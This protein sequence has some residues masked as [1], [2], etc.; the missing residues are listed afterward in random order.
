[1]TG[2]TTAGE[3][4]S[5]A[6][7]SLQELT[8]EIGTGPVVDPRGL[9]AAWPAFQR[10]GE[11]LLVVITA[12]P[13]EAFDVLSP[14]RSTGVLDVA[15]SE[16][17][18][19]RLV[20]AAD[21]LHAAADLLAGRDRSALTSAVRLNDAAL[22]SEP[23]LTGAYLVAHA[24]LRDPA[25]FDV[26][27][28]AVQ[29]VAR[30]SATAGS[31][32]GQRSELGGT[33]ED[34]TTLPTGVRHSF[35][36]G[37]LPSAESALDV[38]QL[39][40]VAIH[41]WEK[42]AVAAGQLAAPS[43]LDLRGSAR[44]AGSLLALT[45][46]LLRSYPT[47]TGPDKEPL[48]AAASRIQAAGISW[49]AA[50]DWGVVT[51]ATPADPT[52][53]TAT[54]ALDQAISLVAR[55]GGH[56]ASPDEVARRLDA[57]HAFTVA[58]SALAALQIVAEQHAPVITRL[59]DT[60]TLYA[61]AVK[62]T[63]TMERV[64]DRIARRWVPVT[65]AEARE[66]LEAYRQL[67]DRTA[68]ARLAFTAVTSPES[69]RTSETVRFTMS[70]RAAASHAAVVARPSR[71]DAV[72]APDET[73]A[74]QRWQRT[75]EALDPRLLADPHW[76]TLA[77]ALDRI[78][79]AGVDVTTTLN[80]AVTTGPLPDEHTARTLHYRLVQMSTAA[81]TPYTSAPPPSLR[82]SRVSGPL[83]SYSTTRELAQAPPR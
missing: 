72:R 4:L 61:P 30:W 18:D 49:N 57:D 69:Q 39:L 59:A 36:A 45:Q 73:L 23:M 19:P 29:A 33:L 60:S 52:L 10:A 82:P 12:E 11:R 67:P 83:T 68:T 64:A 34:V 14:T 41:D 44:A 31:R 8:T 42:A 71:D 5:L 24:T 6:S 7:R 28:R 1:M 47:A 81:A 80:A 35:G 21:L 51:T 75:C 78:E 62:V 43:S 26:A 22:A 79:L 70:Q 16:T 77:G 15:F 50:A 53:L 17:A 13:T 27:A 46:V 20:H 32:P 56:W 48:A 66:L 54:S 9:A 65:T 2:P 58:R 55:S 38:A 25:H 63:A 76:P 40:H 3:L 37:S 74:G